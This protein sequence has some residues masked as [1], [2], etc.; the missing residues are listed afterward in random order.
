MRV[1]SLS[2]AVSRR[3]LARARLGGRAGLAWLARP[4]FW[5]SVVFW[6]RFLFPRAAFCCF[7]LIASNFCLNLK[8]VDGASLGVADILV[9]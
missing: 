9:A 2:V 4:P 3:V 7:L 8:L 5:F 1:G 6:A